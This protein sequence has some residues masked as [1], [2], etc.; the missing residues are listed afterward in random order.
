[1]IRTISFSLGLLVVIG[2]FV[3][4]NRLQK[5]QKLS[6]HPLPPKVLMIGDSLSVGGFG[7]S[8]RE[9]LEKEFG[10]QNVAFFASCGSSPE[11]WLQS[12]PVFQTRCGYR[13]KTP[14]TDVYRDYHNGKRPPPVVTPKIETLIE[15][16]K[17][18]IVIVQLGTNWMDQTLSDNHIRAVLARFVSTFHRS[19][20][21]RMI[22][23]GPPDSSRFSK[24]QN[25]IYR[26]IQQSL[27]RGDPLI[28]SRR[29]TRYVFGKTGGDGIHYNSESGE[30][31]ARPVIANIDQVLAADIAA[32]R[33]VASNR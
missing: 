16:Y 8:V 18:T 10:R 29:F 23:I 21:Q 26:L 4:A 32:R 5:P 1:M 6:P 25:R 31:W 7:E 17:P 9:H 2:S 19:G 12:E 13:E 30:A 27:P 24:V 14:T 15:R 33:K 28:D 3:L 11:S 20:V 22:W